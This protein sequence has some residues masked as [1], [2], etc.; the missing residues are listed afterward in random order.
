MKKTTN[1]KTGA[2]PPNLV[3][4]AMFAGRLNDSKIYIFGG[5]ASQLNGTFSPTDPNPSTGSLW[6]FDPSNRIWDQADVESAV[7]LRPSYGS[8]VDAVDQGLGFYLNGEIDRGSDITV[9]SIG[10]Q[11]LGLTGLV[12]LNMTN[13]GVVARNLST[14]AL[15]HGEALV[16][17]ELAYVPLVGKKGILVALGGAT[18]SPVHPTS[19]NGTLVG[20]LSE[21]S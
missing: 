4:G 12:M 14:A 1:P 20:F 21:F 7:P 19:K 8:Y 15:W 13:N 5:T 18:V 11:T 17:S 10:N 6:S 3:R 2:N 9:N 16:S